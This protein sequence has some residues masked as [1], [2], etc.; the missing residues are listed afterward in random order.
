VAYPREGTVGD[1]HGSTTKTVKRIATGAQGLGTHVTRKPRPRDWNLVA[2]MV[3]SK[4]KATKQRRGG[5]R[6]QVSLTCNKSHSDMVVAVAP[7]SP[8]PTPMVECREP[9]G[10]ENLSGG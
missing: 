1:T 3:A 10:V 5:L 6:L 4:V 8:D 9:A 2:E 7:P